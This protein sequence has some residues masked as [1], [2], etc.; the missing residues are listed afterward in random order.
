M[1]QLKG[2]MRFGNKGKVSP[3]YVGPYEIFQ[4]VCK[5]SYELRLSSELASV[6]WYYMYPFLRSSLVTLSP[7]FLLKV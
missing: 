3:H 5:V 2:A 4:R 1:F 6:I 7:F